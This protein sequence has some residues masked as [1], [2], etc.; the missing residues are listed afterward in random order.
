MCS[1][2]KKIRRSSAGLLST[3]VSYTNLPSSGRSDDGGSK[4]PRNVR[5]RLPDIP[6]DSHLHV[7]S[8]SLSIHI[9]QYFPFGRSNSLSLKLLLSFSP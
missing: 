3:F 5:K 2:A 1:A 4:H 6:E 9:W 7:R 8:V